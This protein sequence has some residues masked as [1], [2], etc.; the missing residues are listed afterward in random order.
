MD[1]DLQGSV[2]AVHPCEG[3]CHEFSLSSSSQRLDDDLALR[4]II[5]HDCVETIS[6]LRAERHT[7]VEAGEVLRPLSCEDWGQAV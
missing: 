2:N 1:Y 7:R 3:D 5:V 4:R 6:H